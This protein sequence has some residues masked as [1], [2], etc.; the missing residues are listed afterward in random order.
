MARRLVLT[1]TAGGP[2]LLCSDGKRPEFYFFYSTVSREQ[3]REK[4]QSFETCFSTLVVGLT[5]AASCNVDSFRQQ[6]QHQ[7]PSAATTPVALA[8]AT[9][10]LKE[11]K[12][13]QATKICG[14]QHEAQKV[15]FSRIEINCKEV[16]KV[17]IDGGRAVTTVSI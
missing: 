7:H 1:A 12:N 8:V 11:L 4:R 2:T 13:L 15:S 17:Y 3:E 6:Q 5:Q 16:V 9:I 10:T 14:F